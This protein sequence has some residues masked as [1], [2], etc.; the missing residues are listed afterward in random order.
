[1]TKFDRFQALQHKTDYTMMAT[2]QYDEDIDAL[3]VKGFITSPAMR[4]LLEEFD[5][6][7]LTEEGLVIR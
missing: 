6:I 2:A 4:E 5:T 1:M 3:I 7:Y